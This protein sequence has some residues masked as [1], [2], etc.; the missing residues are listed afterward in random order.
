MIGI[1]LKNLYCSLVTVHL[2]T[3]VD[4]P[5]VSWEHFNW[6]I[7]YLRFYVLLKNFSLTCIWRCH[8]CRWRAAK[9]RSLLGDQDLWAGRDLYR[10]TPTV[11]QGL[12]FSNLIWRTAAPFS[13]LLRHTRGCGGSIL[14]R[15]LMGHILIDKGLLI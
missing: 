3:T 15:I 8:H 6:L 13:C 12:G 4:R 14:T 11:T 1:F 5:Y 2:E 7:D 10:A 9:F